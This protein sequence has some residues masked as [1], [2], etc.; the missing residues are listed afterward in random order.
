MNGC[1]NPTVL[2][3]E[4]VKVSN[5]RL[6]DVLN[7]HGGVIEQAIY[8]KQPWDIAGR[9]GTVAFDVSD[10]SEGTHAA[11]PEFWWTDQPIPAPNDDFPVHEM[12]ARNTVGVSFAAS[13]SP[14]CQGRVTVDAISVVRE[15][16]LEYLRTTRPAAW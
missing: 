5:G 8:P 12:L 9:T 14:T 3:P 10:D 15:S 2:P 13:N 11:W 4:T 6:Y 1:G 16:R 7:D